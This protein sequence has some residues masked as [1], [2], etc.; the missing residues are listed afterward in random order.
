MD[1]LGEGGGGGGGGGSG[2]EISVLTVATFFLAAHEDKA[3]RVIKITGKTK[4]NFRFTVKRGLFLVFM[5]FYFKV[6]GRL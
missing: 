2:G 6:D 5:I 1:Y 3:T 4:N